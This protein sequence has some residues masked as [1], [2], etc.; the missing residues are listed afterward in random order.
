MFF[1]TE[2]DHVFHGK[3][4]AAHTNI[5]ES[6][7]SKVEVCHFWVSCYQHFTNFISSILQPV[8]IYR[9]LI[10]YGGMVVLN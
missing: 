2:F 10:F 5:I 6:T 1:M 3:R 7:K 9:P 4:G 8:S